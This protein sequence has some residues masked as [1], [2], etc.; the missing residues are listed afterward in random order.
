MCPN[1]SEVGRAINGEVAMPVGWNF[2]LLVTVAAA[3]A[4]PAS[5]QT[6][7]PPIATA[8]NT[9][10]AAPAIPD[11][12]GI[13]WHPSL[14]NFEPLASGPRPVTNLS[15]RPDTGVSYYGQLVGDYNNPILQPW[16]AEVVKKKGELSLAGV[17]FPNPA[18]TCWPEPVPFLFKHAAMQML[19]LSDQIV[20]MFNE[21]HEVRRVR[22]NQPHPA[23]VTP[24]WHGDAVG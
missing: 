14:P 3:I 13:W 11:L 1:P 20:M 9:A 19:Q 5:G 4:T 2:L 10:Q 15:R 16:A 17:V 12:S 24:S 8:K 22:L 18:N 23:K 7:A 21:N 6:M